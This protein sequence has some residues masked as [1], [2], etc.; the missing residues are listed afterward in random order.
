MSLTENEIYFWV[1][2][3]MTC[4][5]IIEIPFIM[6]EHTGLVFICIPAIMLSTSVLTAVVFKG[7]E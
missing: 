2:L 1:Y 7:D 4:I 3:I 6:V 5:L